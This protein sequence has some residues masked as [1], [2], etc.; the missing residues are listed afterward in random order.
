MRQIK[1]DYMA[2]IL[3]GCLLCSCMDNTLLSSSS[4]E[5]CP[6]TDRD[7]Y[8]RVSVPRTYGGPTGD[9]PEML[10]ETLDVLVFAKGKTD[11]EYYVQ[12]ACEGKLTT[13]RDQFEVIMPIGEGL[14]IHV[15]ANC[16]DDMVA[17]NFYNSAGTRMDAMLE[18][19]TLS[20]K[21]INGAAMT[22]LPMHGYITG[23]NI[24]KDTTAPLEVPVLRSVAGAQVV[25]K[26][27][28]NAA[29]PNNPV[30]GS[31][32]ITDDK[33]NVIF[34][35]RELYAFFV[36]GSALS[37]AK[38]EAYKP[39]APDQTDQTREVKEASLPADLTVTDADHPV[40]IKEPGRVRQIGCLYL[41]ENKPW[42]ENGFDQPDESRTAA[43]TRLVV[44]GVYKGATDAEGQPLVTYY[45]I[46][47][48]Q[49]GTLTDILRNHKYTFSIE[50]VSGPGY[51][52]PE[53]AATGVPINIYVKLIDWTSVW[54][55]IDFD[56]ENYLSTETRNIVLPRDADSSKTISMESDVELGENWTLSFDKMSTV[57]G[58]S[59]VG[60]VTG[61]QGA[62]TLTISNTRYKVDITGLTPVKE[63]VN[64]FT[65]KVTA[66]K[67]YGDN[68]GIQTNPPTEAYDDVLYIKI[69]NLK[70]GI[71]LSQA[72]RSPDDWGSGGDLDTEVGQSPAIDIG[73]PVLFAWGNVI[74]T[75]A[76]DGT[77][78][79]AFAEEQGYYSGAIYGGDYFCWNRLDPKDDFIELPWDNAHDVCRKRGGKWRTPTK[80]EME[81]LA[82]MYNDGLTFWGTYQMKD[83]SL[84]NGRYFGI[85]I[86]P[87]LSLQDKYLFLPAAGYR[88]H[89]EK[90]AGPITLNNAGSQ[91]G[92][93]TS[94]ALSGY[95]YYLMLH[96]TVAVVYFTSGSGI[97]YRGNGYSVRC[98][99]DK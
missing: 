97:N 15:F 63:G 20:K 18:R 19:L 4:D 17:N 7:M 92:Y 88:Y 99:K 21:V 51:D 54:D 28:L 33:G 70:V 3:L 66:L 26:A 6:R 91:G 62:Q 40:F 72:D 13:T 61:A 86:Q 59:T 44:G 36:P 50:K 87:G 55:N 52:T 67:A 5:S 45:R 58:N 14:V 76:G 82:T 95:G 12:A 75:P 83:G 93:W 35:M 43:T 16:H 80:T 74:A 85:G 47:F 48:A 41:Y 1:I 25:T 8:L 46:D 9:D 98:V 73:L 32:D 42:S 38:P 23:V 79:Y 37:S 60:E 30:A 27:T 29:D 34:D 89:Q 53:E 2:I 96:S 24:T 49:G 39:L 78:T 77:Y 94:D 56:N 10:V 31:G 22:S 65:L 81:M 71:N 84:K 69:K 64:P 68:A 57:N 90:G 11:S